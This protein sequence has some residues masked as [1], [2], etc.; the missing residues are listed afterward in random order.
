MVETLGQL[1]A[2]KDLPEC[3]KVTSLPLIQYAQLLQ[4]IVRFSAGVE[5][6]INSES[7]AHYAKPLRPQCIWTE[8]PLMH[9]LNIMRCHLLSFIFLRNEGKFQVKELRSHEYLSVVL[10]AVLYQ[11]TRDIRV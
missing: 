2:T 10:T 8:T 9:V 5:H 4:H 7:L 6:L 3:I 11:R 1:I